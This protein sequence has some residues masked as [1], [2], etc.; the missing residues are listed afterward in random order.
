[1]ILVFSTVDRHRARRDD[2]ANRPFRNDIYPYLILLV[3]G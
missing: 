3:G 1:V 2:E